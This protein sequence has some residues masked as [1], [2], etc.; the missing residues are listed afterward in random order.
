LLI[1]SQANVLEIQAAQAAR[2]NAEEAFK[3][4]FLAQRN[5]QYNGTQDWLSAVNMNIDH[6]GYSA[7]RQEHPSAGKW[8]L[9]NDKIKSWLDPDSSTISRIWLN[10]IPG[11]GKNTLSPSPQFTPIP[12]VRF[13]LGLSY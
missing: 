13:S 10:G 12:S 11:A 3:Q 9:T 7:V 8:M 1:E 4:M 5:T 2:S 6:E